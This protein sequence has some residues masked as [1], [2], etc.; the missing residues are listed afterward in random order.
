MTQ[1]IWINNYTALGALCNQLVGQPWVALDT[2]FR[3]EA[4]FYP[5]LCLIQIATPHLIACIDALNIAN[6]K[7]LATFLLNSQTL[8]V[9]HATS[10]DLEVLTYLLGAVSGPV[11]DTQLAAALLGLSEQIGYAALVQ[12]LTGATLDK[13]QC[14]TDW[15]RRPLTTAQLQYAADDVRYLSVIYPIITKRLYVQNRLHWLEEDCARLV[16]EVRL[17]PD[18]RTAWARIR[19]AHQLKGVQLTALQELAAWRE[20]QA[21]SLDRPRNWIVSEQA[22]L[23]IAHRLPRSPAELERIPRLKPYQL[24]QHADALLA[25][26]ARACELPAEHGPASLSVKPLDP[27]QTALLDRLSLLVQHTAKA[28]CIA[29]AVLATRGMLERL[30]R[31]SPEPRLTQGWRAALMG[32]RL[33]ATLR[34]E[35]TMVE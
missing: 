22:L 8:K 9:L 3:R 32:D 18:P 17:K 28:H 30:V 25:A 23:E 34:G 7:P 11:F 10:Q 14:R 29:P 24:P 12:A 33:Q 2:E 15:S 4:T 31:G 16:R 13:S 6:L 21:M 19:G 1:P 35:Q 20:Q 27:E 26:V 5:K